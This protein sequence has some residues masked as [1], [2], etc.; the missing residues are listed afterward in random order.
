MHLTVQ[1][2]PGEFL[3]KMTILEIKA[4]R[5]ENPEKLENV[6]RELA[7]LRSTWQAS[8]LSGAAG[9]DASA[10][11]SELREVNTILWEVEDRI[12]LKEAAAAFDAE[13]IELARSVYRTNDRRAAIKRRLNVLLG[14]D[15]IEEKSYTADRP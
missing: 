13:F 5:I 15:L 1:T 8:P 2:S 3:D 14:S 7:L 11:V 10:L 4:D 12:R 6:R 9:A